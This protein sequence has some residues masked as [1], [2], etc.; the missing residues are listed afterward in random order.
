MDKFTEL[1]NYLKEEGLTDL[2]A[3]EFKV[4][5]AAGTAKNTELYSY[6]KD[7]K[8]TDLDAE[9]FNNQYFTALEKKNPNESSQSNVEE[10]ITD[11]TIETP[12]V[13][14]TSVD[15]T[16]V[17]TS[18]DSN[19]VETQSD[20][21][22][23]EY[24]AYDP[25]EQGKDINANAITYDSTDSQFDQSLAFV[26]KD[27]IDREESEV[28]NRMKYH[29]EDYGFDFEEGGSV[30]D[31]LDGMTVTS[32]DDP[33]K[34]ITVNLDPVFGN[35]FGGESGPAKE[36]KAFLKA[37]RRTDGKMSELTTGYD[38]NRKK[39][40]SLEGTKEDIADVENTA[41]GLNKKYKSY[42]EEKT[43]Q[44]SEMDVLMGQSQE[45]KATPEWQ[46]EYELA[47]S[48]GKRL[49]QTRNVLGDNFK[50]YKKLKTLVDSSVGN[51]I[52]MK[53]ADDSTYVG[54]LL[55]TFLGPG[56][57]DVL[58]S[59][60]GAGV[61]GFY[62]AVQS[63][64]EDFGMTPEEKKDRYI[65]IAR[66]LKYPVPENIEDE[67]VYK[68]WLD[69]LQDKGF[70]PEEDVPAAPK[71]DGVRLNYDDQ[72]NIDGESSH[73]MKTETDGKGNWFSFPTLFQ[74]KD[75]TWVDMSEQAEIDWK[76]V[77]EEA[78]KRGEV[79]EFGTDKEKALAYGDGS[80][81]SKPSKAISI[82]GF[83]KETLKRLE[84]DGYDLSKPRLNGKFFNEKQSGLN[85]FINGQYID[86]P[87]YAYDKTKGE[88]LKRL[89]LDQEVKENKNPQKDSIKKYLNEILSQ[90]DISDEKFAKQNKDG[91]ADFLGIPVT[92]GLTGLA[93]SL[94][95]VLVSYLSRGKIAPAVGIGAA[96]RNLIARG[97]G[98]T[99]KGG[100]AQTVS[101]S[102]LQAEAMNEEMNNDPD[103]KY[104]TESERKKIVIPTAITVGILER[105]GFRH[106]I[107]NKTIVTGL[108]NTVTNM[109]PKGAT[110]VMFR[111][112]MN[113]VVQNRIAK[114]LLS[115]T[116]VKATMTFTNRVARATAAEAETGGLQQFA[117]MGYKDVW[118][119][120]NNKEMFDQTKFDLWSLEFWKTIGHAAAAEAV[121]G[122]VM[123][124]PGA[125]INAAKRGSEELVS[126]DMVELF[127]QIANDGLTRDAHKIQLDLDVAA[128][129]RTQKDVDQE[130]LEFDTLR[131]ALKELP[132][133]LDGNS[134]KKGLL[135]I[136]EQQK[137]EAEMAK[138]NKNLNSYKTKEARVEEIKES[139]GQLGT[140]Q[141]QANTNLK[142]ET[143]G[144]Q[145]S[146]LVTE[147]D[148][149]KSLQD[150]GVQNPTV[151]QI[152]T[153]Q[154]ALQKQSTESVDAQESST[155]SET[156]GQ[157]VSNEQSTNESNTKSEETK[158]KTQTQEEISEDDQNDIDDFFGDT[159]LDEVE[160]TSDNLSIN[161]KQKKGSTEIENTS[162]AAAV[163]NKAKKA[164]RAIKKLAPNVKI[165]L[166]DTQAEY[167]KYG[168]K[169]SRGYYN[170]NSKVI[171][172]NLTKAKGNTVAHEVFHAVFLEKISG[173]DIQAQLA[174]KKLITAVRKTLPVDSM[175]AKRIDKFAKNYDDN[176]KDEE[177]LAELFS[178]MSSEYKTL[179]KPAKNKIIEFIRS[180]AAKVGI[181]IPGGF[182]KTD[183]SVIDFLNTFSQKVR[184]GTE[185]T[186]ADV[187]VLNKINE[188]VIVEQGTLVE[189]ADGVIPNEI[190]D[191]GPSID[192]K[193][194][195]ES[196]IDRGGID[197]NSIK[198]GSINE[199]SGTNAFVFAAD[200]ATYGEVESP[201]GNKFKFDGGYLYPYGSEASGSE[202]A[203]VFS[204][205]GA[206]NKVLNKVNESD[207]VGLVMSQA[208]NGITGNLQ[209]LEYINSEI[210]YAIER[211]ASPKEMLAYIN[212]KLKLTKVANGLSKRGFPAQI[213]S[214][215]QL[216]EI[217]IPLNFEQR[218]E[219]TEKFL[220]K[221]SYEKFNISPFSP[222]K[223]V[224]TNISDIVNDPTLSKIGYGDIVSA[225][226][227]E[228]SGKPFK[229][230]KGEPGYHP[231]YPWAI[232]GKGLMVFNKGV[233][234]RK[235]YPESKPKSKEA[236]QT[237]LGKRTKP[238]AA[239]SAMG[240]Q[241]TAKVPSNIKVE[242]SEI[243]EGR[244]QLTASKLESNLESKYNATLDIYENKGFLELDKIII[245]EDQ[246]NK[247]TGT[248]MMNEVIAFA[249]SKGLTIALT[250]SKSYGATSVERLK[251]F[252][253][254]LGFVENKGSNKDFSTKQSMLKLPSR[255]GREQSTEQQ[256]K[257]Q[258]G[259]P[260]SG[261]YSAQAMVSDI[262]R[263]FNRIG[264]GYTA[265]RAKLG[266]FG[267]GGGVYV[268]GPK[269]RVKNP[270]RTGRQQVIGF[271]SAFEKG[272][273]NADEN[274]SDGLFIATEGGQIVPNPNVSEN[275]IAKAINSP[276]T[277]FR[278][279][280]VWQT[281]NSYSN[282]IKGVKISKPA[283][284]KVVKNP[285]GSKDIVVTEKGLLEYT[286]EPS[287][288]LDESA[289][290]LQVKSTSSSTTKNTAAI[291]EKELA[292][293][294]QRF[295]PKDLKTKKDTES[296]ESK[297]KTTQTDTTSETEV[298]DNEN[299]LLRIIVA[300]R[301]EGGFTNDAILDY[302]RRRKKTVDGKTVAAYNIKEIRGAFKVLESE[303]FDSYMFREY[304]QSF[305]DIKGGFLAGLKLMK[306]VD[307]YYKKL[308]E[309]NNLIKNRVKKNKKTKQ[310][311]LSD[312]QLNLKVLDFF[313]D[314]AGYK[315]AGVKG[316]RQTSQQLAMERDMLEILLPDPLKAN[317]QRIAAINRRISN[318]KFD[319]RN[320]KGVQR[321]LRNYIR[322]VLPRDLYTKKEITDLIDKINR[323]N[324]TNF[325][326]V[327]DEVFKIVTIKT[328]T[329]LQ[330]ILFEILKKDYTVVQSGRFKG[331]K[332]DNKTRKKLNR[333][334]KLIISKKIEDK[335]G[336]IIS[337]INPEATEEQITKANIK[338]LEKYNKFAKEEVD[339]KKK[340]DVVIINRQDF[341]ENDL[342]A[343][344]EITLAMQINT[345]FTQEM[346]DPNKTTQLNS[347]VSSLNQ[348]E[349]TGKANLEYQLLQD[350]IKYRENDRAVYKDMT[351]VDLDAKQS[352]IDQGIPENEIT[353]YMIN[354]E[355]REMSKDIAQDAKESGGL[356][357]KSVLAR[358]TGSLVSVANSIEQGVF[359]T[360]EDM[361]GLIDRISTQP[362]EIF[363]G[364]TQEITQK[365]IRKATRTFKGR[366]LNQQLVF[367]EKMTELLGKRWTAQNRKNSRETETI[368]RSVVKADM[369]QDQLNVVQRTIT[370]KN[371]SEVAAKVKEIQKKI[372][373]NTINIS[374]NQLL[375]YY[376]QM[377][378]PSLNKSMIN[379]FD[380]TRLG[381][382]SFA[383]E[384]DSRIKQE[385]ADKL[386]DKLIQLSEWMIGEYYP[387][388]YGHYN[389][390]Y[391]EVY[392][393]DM[394]WNQFYAG[395][396][397]RQN[398]NEAEGL[399]LLAD[400]QSWITNVGNASTKARKANTNKI[401]KTDG[402]DALLNY[403]KDMEYFAA[404]AVPIRNIN[405]IFQN[406][407]IKETIKDKFGPQIW[408]YINDS[409]TKIANKG[410]QAQNETAI[411]NAFNNTF[412]L[413]RLGLNPTLILKQ[414]TSF[415]T[416]GND[417]GYLN[418]VKN[419]AMATPKARTLIKE[420]LDNSLVLKDRYGQSITR[421]VENYSDDKFERMNGGLL[422][423]FGLTNTKQDQ[424]SKI[425]MWTTMA[426]DKGA[427]LVGGVPNYLYY[428]NKFKE[429]NPNATEQEA[430]DYAIIKF[431][432]DTLRTQQSYDLQD[433]DYFQTK[434]AFVRAFN[435]FLTTPKQYFRREIIAARNMYR[436]IK[437]GGKQG[438]GTVKD[439]GELD[440][441]RSLGKSARSL[442]VYHVV[443][444]VIFQWV[445][446][447]LPGL[448]RGSDDDDKADLARAAIIG[449]LNALFII[450]KIGE[451]IMDAV[452]G[453]PWAGTPSTIP[454][455]GQTA[456]L[457]T[458]YVDIGKT[459]DPIK[460]EEKVN[461]FM[462]EAIALTGVPAG[463]LRKM[464]K[465]FSTIGDSKNLGE[466][467]LKLFNFS[468]YAQGKKNKKTFNLTK[469]ELKKYFPALYPDNKDEDN[470]LLQFQKKY[471][472]EQ[473]ELRE[474]ILDEIYN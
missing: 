318:I 372:D 210:N 73:I 440:Y 403:T 398:E 376:S 450:G 80:W 444:P 441:W 323:V 254:G 279:S 234:V 71:R 241:F 182:G 31:G 232:P 214:L 373:S 125:V 246:R 117:E 226:Q 104:V 370:K 176:L 227:F 382:V 204:T 322:M 263:Q 223:T 18:T 48:N 187:D 429:K 474:K 105:L 312:E 470:E 340:G 152:K 163:V 60:W 446:Q 317:P 427:I 452:S 307:N 231:A 21:M 288:T 412:L 35:I 248:K 345:S 257:D 447:G 164:A 356:E 179:K 237:P 260:A 59:V 341:S 418:W 30:L 434:G 294:N 67:A 202:A 390:T 420:V 68:K 185:I 173:G 118:N 150:K 297:T 267:G 54:G 316:K 75:G 368:V 326:S 47:L 166:H 275:E 10:V 162:M 188:D 206:A 305:N 39:Y 379:T 147:E 423:R 55:N 4:Q 283:K 249:D 110:A 38:R 240:G 34:S 448:L 175:L 468:E 455:L 303:A 215:E 462:A 472:K 295:K 132:A 51:Y 58:A 334:N 25:R 347:V 430:I 358:F 338:L 219:F 271:S 394:P 299:D 142:N 20:T 65:D 11:S 146:V 437:S 387:E 102:L 360:A 290:R 367:S 183:E 101:F 433:K 78:K 157:G 458:L 359:G 133:D 399:D 213:N 436:I 435:M 230:S 27:L 156:M 130:M 195:R 45:A 196:Q 190:E 218:G 197:M 408:K 362:G 311:P 445:S 319:E 22:V 300:A 336:K 14:D 32:K 287:V 76:P 24:P 92:E 273:I 284:Y 383:N 126:D 221:D 211:G 235:V 177:T 172:I 151:E 255:Q 461:K 113:K 139:I 252:Y 217:M 272:K 220:S 37:N 145:E 330:N 409:I 386:D 325:D 228:K 52:D 191:D 111:N 135:L 224:P 49:Q 153:E 178:L 282:D 469:R 473:K 28:V 424:I 281:T 158:S 119:N 171:H 88:R 40:F 286:T 391:K 233:D 198:R 289:Q 201:S 329:R 245:S 346:N 310:I 411:I 292:A 410:I 342:E 180:M 337:V 42:L 161:R 344:A 93:K 127:D 262:Q 100:I 296:F 86:L 26:T 99:T 170:P 7:E 404:Y 222:L 3:E 327:K 320:L 277:Y 121:G 352:L 43:T 169:K 97:L 207:G 349:T 229:L 258:T 333:I 406:P 136:F 428:K 250:P 407:L 302:L 304:P 291:K 212:T 353:E 313:M 381:D 365:E 1:Y 414:M 366:M 57:S 380:A 449:N 103:F 122:F 321:A 265:K 108:M 74:D 154:D 456:L 400:S 94:P 83:S 280:G 144:I 109:L 451:T 343:M 324:A 417:I 203:W 464:M 225:I 298:M 419:A 239:R 181:E 9:N 402:I 278:D 62:K 253:K 243:R 459:K 426:G 165:V 167:E 107:G 85:K 193:E 457:A 46:L 261:Y 189:E 194:G 348:I 413:S 364:A 149:T 301:E 106:L 397:Y 389:N 421:T 13:V 61:D 186:E 98:L 465:N 69:G 90:D 270:T 314:Q 115:S 63:V 91:V 378:D 36:L 216:S 242:G 159:V 453:K 371:K 306:Q 339:G 138:I 251:S 401:N 2:S 416:Y 238:A 33:S 442:A 123:G 439:N 192:F 50:E 328:N 377:Q 369:L 269:G 276:D 463:Q 19:V 393:T 148:A 8:L 96:K 6:L 471:K 160:T 131:G 331:V 308:V 405:K 466:F 64:N 116:A 460:R 89:V 236:N 388:S 285:D 77:Y 12:E 467:I 44:Q 168:T 443:M 205:E 264:P 268:N 16:V 274:I 454:V 432:A 415:V 209:F 256:V 335:N 422:E 332:I 355:F 361:T 350:A 140:D 70:D 53:E 128:G 266:A 374:Q 124:V 120:M 208:K 155:G 81:K 72:G 15:S 112:T 244:E 315:S 395:R 357:A 354:K 199:L 143:E 396:V 141:A 425:L 351:G 23:T 309:N 41:K 184:T 79:I 66:D 384:F 392:R 174:A 87:D 293:L 95:S 114:G 84:A 385:I 247:G 134:R 17:D 438:K 5:Y 82:G 56:I 29:F 363:E 375:Y 129:T 431:E 200:Q 259:M 137:L